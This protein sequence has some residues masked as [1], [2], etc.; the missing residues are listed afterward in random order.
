MMPYWA[1]FI[2]GF[3]CGLSVIIIIKI[4]SV[5]KDVRDS[6]KNELES[7]KENKK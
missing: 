4:P 1:W 3:M 5:I 6:K 2:V 7:K